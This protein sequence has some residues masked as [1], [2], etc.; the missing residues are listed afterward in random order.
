MNLRRYACSCVLAVICAGALSAAPASAANL[1]RSGFDLR[2]GSARASVPAAQRVARRA[3]RSQLGTR[4]LL[5]IDAATGRPRVVG[6]LD[7]ALTAPSADTG[8]EIALRFLRKHAA[9]YGLT[10]AQIGAL[11]AGAQRRSAAGLLSV[12]LT[13]SFGGVPSIDSGVRAVLDARGRLIEIV[14]APDP[15]LAVAGTTAAVSRKQAATLAAKASGAPA[16][17]A[18][19]RVAAVI[20][21][22][23]PTARLGW[24]VLVSAGPRQVDDVLVD[25]TS[26]AVVRRANRVVSANA[27]SVYP[28]WPDAPLGGSPVAVD[29]APYLENP[30]APTKLKGPNAH[31]FTDAADVVPGF[32]FT[33]IPAPGSDVGPSSGTDFNYPFNGLTFGPVRCPTAGA[34]CAWD[35]QT[36][37]SWQ[38][39]RAQD[40]VQLFWLVNNFHDHLAAAPIGFDGG[41]GAFEGDDA[42]LAQSL[43]GAATGGNGLPDLDHLD[44]ANFLPL[45]DGIPGMMQ[46]YLFGAA[47]SPIFGQDPFFWVSGSDDASIVYHEYA[48]G[49][50]NRLVTDFDGFGALNALQSGAMGEAWSDWYAFDKLGRD[51]NLVDTP[52]VA[53]VRT[54]AYVE[55]TQDLIR[56]EPIDCRVDTADPACPGTPTA[57]S[58]GYTFGDLGQVLGFPEVH[59]DG[60]IWS[61]TLWQLR[62]A[63]IAEHGT[64]AGIAR[65]EQLVTDAMRLSPPEPS[66]LDQR[67]AILQADAIDAPAGQDADTIWA[68]FAERGMGWFAA[69]DN[70]SQVRAIEDFA[71]PPDAAAGS[72]TVEG[73]VSADDA[74]VASVPVGFAGHD[75]GLGVDLSAIT[76]AGG[77]Y[78]IADVP[79]GTYP[80]LRT[81]LPPGYAGGRITDVIVP[82][83]GSSRATSRGAATGPRRRPAPP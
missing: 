61:Q 21:H 25:A 63:L 4:A 37:N 1:P 80:T 77:A 59:A 9:V 76:D 12:T 13:Q 17:A 42:I 34:T 72:A 8:A 11:G 65:A 26:G 82:S 22:V 70:A 32:G 45:P 74:P 29:L 24:R 3:L 60:E 43:D 78:A 40:A 35:P 30:G 73:V 44:N 66:F 27:A 55:G 57:G 20:F 56:S 51:G 54:G 23:G 48:H 19:A 38:A 41:D 18:G 81:Q 46:M 39:N 67:N 47:D 69:I 33:T 68:V 62:D 6:R 83:S 64:V 10:S 53:D 75:S 49:L 16:R 58:G 31:A 5:S 14:G 71:L 7:G 52:G 28:A 50:S 2:S 15:D 79:A 36:A